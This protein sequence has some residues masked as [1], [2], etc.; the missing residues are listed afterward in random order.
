MSATGAS[1]TPPGRM[2]LGPEHPSQPMKQQIE[3]PQEVPVMTLSNAVLF[4]QGNSTPAYF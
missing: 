3:I 4:P 1:E 2:E